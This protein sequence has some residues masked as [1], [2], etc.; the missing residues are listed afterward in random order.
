[1]ITGFIISI[2]Y[3][4]FYNIINA[5]PTGDL[6]IPSGFTDGITLIVQYLH[7]WSWLLPVDTLISAVIFVLGVQLIVLSIKGTFWV[8]RTVRGSGS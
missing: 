3:T 1:M 8:I 7:A 4:L 2:F 6:G 5:F